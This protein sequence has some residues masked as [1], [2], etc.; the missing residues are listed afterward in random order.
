MAPRPYYDRDLAKQNKQKRQAE[1]DA[2]FIEAA[3][4]VFC[5]GKAVILIPG[6]VALGIVDCLQEQRKK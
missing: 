2:A 5:T 4:A 6:K 1:N 3:K